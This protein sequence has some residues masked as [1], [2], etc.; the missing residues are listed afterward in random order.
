MN[1]NNRI[2]L[3]HRLILEGLS[4]T[5]FKH[6]TEV[7]TISTS[8][9]KVH[10]QK[11]EASKLVESKEIEKNSR[12]ITVYRKIEQKQEIENKTSDITMEEYNNRINEIFKKVKNG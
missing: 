11:L 3:T 1:N 6:C 7:T 9:F 12:M 4:T 10:I 2:K 8:A 5:E